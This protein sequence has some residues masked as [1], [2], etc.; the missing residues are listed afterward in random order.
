M[1]SDAQANRDRVLTAAEEVF[2]ESGR[3]GSTEEIARRAGVG[4]GTVFRH[5]PTKQL[6]VEA[7]VVRHLTRLT[8]TARTRTG[9]AEAGKAFRETVREMVAGAPAKLALV[10]RLEAT[11]QQPVT[12]AALELK[13]AVGV[14]LDRAQESG[15][16]RADV[17]VDEVYVLISALSN[18]QGEPAVVG[19]AVDIVLDGLSGNPLSQER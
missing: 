2:G 15:E 5:F 11:G 10:S 12:S 6:L 14:L 7:T 4:I 9:Q 13:E 3:A 16:V 8:G 1:R 17:T 18:A 19:R